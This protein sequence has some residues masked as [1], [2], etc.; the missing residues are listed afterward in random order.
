VNA[1]SLLACHLFRWPLLPVRLVATALKNCKIKT[2]QHVVLAIRTPKLP[3][4]KISRRL[5]F[6]AALI[7]ISHFT[8]V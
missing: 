4:L 6:K 8:Y 7:E 3:S 5:K 2:V 1:W